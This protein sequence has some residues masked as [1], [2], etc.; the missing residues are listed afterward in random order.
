M[1]SERTQVV[2][3][4]WT[5]GFMLI[6]GTACTTLIGVFPPIPA[7]WSPEAVSAFY[8]ANSL[9]IRIGAAIAIGTGGFMLPIA[10]VIS[11][12]MVHL[13]GRVSALSVLQG[14]GGAMMSLWL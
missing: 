11:V 8:T 9:E 4:W 1:M 10:A 6:F 3:V 5:I 2:M 12:Q 7:S 14:M 13:E